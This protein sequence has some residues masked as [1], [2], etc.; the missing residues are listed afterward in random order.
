MAF[1]DS[2]EATEEEE[3]VLAP[4]PDE[5]DKAAP[6]AASDGN[7]SNFQI[8]FNAAKEEGDRDKNTPTAMPM[9]INDD[10]TMSN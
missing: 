10:I 1:N 8:G 5:E 9:E 7:L 2:L 3:T 6:N 4:A